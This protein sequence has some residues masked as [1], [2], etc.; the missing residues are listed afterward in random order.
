MQLLSPPC[1]SS[2][3]CR[4]LYSAAVKS[5]LFSLSIMKMQLGQGQ[6]RVTAQTQ[7]LIIVCIYIAGYREILLEGIGLMN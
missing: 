1:G 5:P 7:H 4:K 3:F 2:V 6:C